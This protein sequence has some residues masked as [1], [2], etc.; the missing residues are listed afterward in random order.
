MTKL[1]ERAFAKISRLPPAEQDALANWLLAEIESEMRWSKLF[2]GSQSIL[3]KLAAEALS[4]HRSDQTQDL[5]PN[6][7]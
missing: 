3:S 2:S 5:D 1:L 6:Q 4:E 7:I